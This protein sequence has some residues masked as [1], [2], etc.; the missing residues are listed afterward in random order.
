MEHLAGKGID[1]LMRLARRRRLKKR[2]GVSAPF[3]LQ[4]CMR[5]FQLMASM[6]TGRE[7]LTACIKGD[8]PPRPYSRIV[9]KMA[10]PA[11]LPDHG[12]GWSDGQTI[13]FPISLTG[14]P[15]VKG[16]SSLAKLLLFF[17]SY[18]IKHGALKH[19]LLNRE[20]LERDNLTTDVYWIVENARLMELL[21][22]D[23]PGLLVDWDDIVRHL[24]P[25]RPGKELLRPI[26]WKVEEFLQLS[27]TGAGGFFSNSSEESMSLAKA[28]R[29]R[30]K[31]ELGRYRGMVP[32]TPYG[33]LIPGRIKGASL[34]TSAA[35]E[36]KEDRHGPDIKDDKGAHGKRVRRAV[37]KTTIDEKENEQGLLL[38]I[39][40]K[41]VSW[42]DFVNVRRPF[43]DDPDDKA[44]DKADEM[45]ELTVAEVQRS[46][47][48]FFDA[49]LEKKD[50]YNDTAQESELDTGRIFSYPEWDWQRRSYRPDFSKVREFKAARSGLDV[51]NAILKDKKDAIREVVRKF[52]AIT[53]AARLKSRQTDGEFIDLDAA[54][55]AISDIEAGVGPGERLYATYTRN[56]RDISA[57]FLV[58]LSMSTD[59]WA[60]DKKIIDHEKETL[61]ILCEAMATL[62]DPHA[63][64]GF[65]GKTRSGC[66]FYHIKGFD[67]RYVDAVRSRIGSVI[68]FSCTRMGPAIRH[69]AGILNRQPSRVRLLFLISDGKPNDLDA[70]EG[71]YGVEDTRMAVKEAQRDGIIPFCLTVDDKAGEYLP[72]L[73]GRGNYAV[74]AGADKLTKSLPDLYARIVRRT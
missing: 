44:G 18:Q 22:S 70:Y 13:F 57:L 27:F 41:I 45:E 48:A 5:R 26:E 40:D 14:M 69:A 73:F 28:L 50:D 60:K 43:D 58:D 24:L 1:A 51:T 74:I 68:P 29:E 30:W 66:C 72:R 33:R 16:Y 46:T 36:D 61:V 32:F 49:A 47:N 25:A 38:N 63:I 10:H 64:Y 39:Y 4:G 56:E 2:L 12:W 8:A 71:R 35:S 65:S 37:T 59:A 52:E 17:Q 11:I 34:S 54:I 53:P 20:M 67:E 31:A 6:I 23:F 15:N 21:R 42:A 55:E 7:A 9:G 62:K 19:T 3:E